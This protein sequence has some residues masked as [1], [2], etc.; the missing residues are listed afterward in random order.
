M[1]NRLKKWKRW[2]KVVH[3]DLQQL[4]V[5]RNIFWE[6]QTIIKNN[7]E[8][9]KPSSFYTYLGDTYVAYISIGIR[10]Q[11][12]V[13]S[14][15]ISFTRLLT[16][17]VDTPS[18]LSRK[19]YTGLYRGSVVEDMADRDF[20]KFSGRGQSH[21]SKDMVSSDLRK[22]YRVASKVE[23][24]VDKRIAHHDKRKP[25]ILPKFDE[26]DA[27]LDVLDKLYVKYHLAFNASSMNSL[28][29]TYQYDWKEIFKVPW[30]RRT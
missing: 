10:R 15:S 12:K 1:D 16:E 3:D 14:Q 8:L 5:N 24:F 29:P 13:S 6:V 26:V 22:L 19:Y 28:M 11:V 25:K 2:L 30:V 9:R 27:C 17:I 7:M 23:D 20:D 18:V 4:L 21:I